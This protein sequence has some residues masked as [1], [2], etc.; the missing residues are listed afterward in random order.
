MEYDF[1]GYATRNDVQCSDG[2]IIRRDAF[3]NCDHSRVPLVWQHD[4]MTPSN[5]LGHAMLENREDGV[6]A[7]GVFNNTSEGLHAKEL[8][9]NGDIRA[10]S[11]Y[12]NKLKHQ[13]RDV[14]HGAIREVSLVLAGAN[15]GAF[16]DTVMAHA[17]D[18]EEEAEIRF[19]NSDSSILL[20]AD[21]M[22]KKKLKK[23]ETEDEDV[24]SEESSESDK[25]K[26]TDKNSEKTDKDEEESKDEED[27]KK[28]GYLKHAE[29]GAANEKTVQ[30][31]IDSMNEE[32]KN[33]LY[34]LVGMAA[35]G[36]IDE[37]AETAGT[38]EK[39]EDMKHNAFSDNYTNDTLI[40]AEE[41]AEIIRDG[42]R[43]GSLRE[44]A[45]QHGY[46]EIPSSLAHADYGIEQ[47]DALFPDYKNVTNVPGFVSRDMSWVT[48]V[49]SAVAH[50]PFS[51]IK[52]VFADIT[53]DEARAKG[54]IKGNKKKEEV[55]TLLKRTTDPQTVY[56]KQKLDRDDVVDIT[57]FD[58][59]SWL[60]GEMR[61]ML[62]EELA[63]AF[64]V[65]DGRDNSSDDKINP[66]HIRP[67]WGDDPFYTIRAQVG[68]ASDATEDDKYVAMIRAA[69]KARKDYKGSGN[70][71][72]YTTE[73]NLTGMLLLTDKMGRDLYESEEQL[74]KKLRVKEIVTVPVMEGLTRNGDSQDPT[75][76]QS[77]TLNF[78][79][80]IVNLSDYNVG[81]DKGGAVNLFDD[82]DIDYNAMK[83][84]IETRCSGA[85]IK[86][87]AAIA[88]E[89]FPKA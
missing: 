3:K 50:T 75:E 35:E 41:M 70:P 74:A 80:L 26:N 83:Y 76:V 22:D 51:R 12:A 33:V 87:Y 56:K 45:F 23:D 25:D 14:V 2:R 29:E 42:K 62:D 21:G 71:T 36:D 40:H 27:K 18:D 11:I 38:E 46:E 47:I 44:S 81:A 66:L 30:D 20:H 88:I 78:E 17:D 61:M 54:Y 58:V 77:K 65:G 4:H 48:K 63:R 15:P 57:D 24:E 67:I 72:F 68:L 32:Q 1:S 85:L 60:K 82:F 69:I 37:D 13:G 55:F 52:T 6:Y 89:T 34:A 19:V 10:L 86:P 5:V 79:G 28:M 64:M 59:V 84:L 9:K 43:Y 73:E 7:Y 39:E 31:V 16:I 53:A 8:V 49:M